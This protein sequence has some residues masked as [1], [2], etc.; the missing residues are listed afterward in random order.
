MKTLKQENTL[1]IGDKIKSFEV[2]NIVEAV[3][4][5]YRNNGSKIKVIAKF[6]LLESENGQQRVLRADKQNLNDSEKWFPTFSNSSK[7]K[8]WNMFQIIK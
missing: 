1:K 6:A 7:F 5:L 2:E 8:S 3:E 4:T